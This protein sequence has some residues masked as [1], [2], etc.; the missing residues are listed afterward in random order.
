[1]N[2]HHGRNEAL[3][4]IEASRKA[5]FQVNIE[6]IFGY[7]GQTL[8]NWAEVIDEAC[9]LDVEE[10]QLYRLKV[11]AYGDYQGPIK[12]VLEKNRQ[13][14]PTNEDSI[15]MKQLAIE[16]LA[17]HGYREQILRRVYT[18][19]PDHYSHYAHNQCCRLLDEVGFGLSAFSSLRDRFVLNTADFNEY[20]AKIEAGQLPVNRGLVRTKEDL[21][22]W[23]VI[24]PLK[25]RTIRKQDFKRV[26]GID[27]DGVFAE[28]FA[29]LKDAG[30]V[31]N[32]KWGL[33]LTTL[34]CFF[35][36]EIVQQF[37]EPHHL[38][39]A[40][41]DYEPGQLHPLNNSEIFG[42]QLEAAE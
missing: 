2:R 16:I 37:F 31:A 9:Q 19:H 39:F 20:Y 28:K 40:P 17:R 1:M 23:A 25:N 22:R 8:E 35:A 7:P 29:A 32:T 27:L 42:S 34:G 24:L 12:Q 11:E 4:A 38:P 14:V 6:F 10:I 26:T 41:D 13:P 21:I 15:V 36:D 30:L 18:R 33:T 3:E 5:G